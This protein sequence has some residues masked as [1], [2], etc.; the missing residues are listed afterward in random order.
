MSDNPPTDEARERILKAATYREQIKKIILE[1]SSS[2][3]TDDNISLKFDFT[4]IP[5]AKR[6]LKVLPL[7]K[8]RLELVKKETAIER[9]YFSTSYYE[10]DYLIDQILVSLDRAKLE[11]EEWILKNSD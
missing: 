11:I 7:I 4:T 8:K 5:E 3:W 1:N 6:Q 9:K 2:T 10:I